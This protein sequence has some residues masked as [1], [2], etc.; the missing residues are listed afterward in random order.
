V[1]TGCTVSGA[2]GYAISCSTATLRVSTYVGGTTLA[3]A[4][5]GV[6][7]GVIGGWDCTL[8]IGATR[9][10][11]IT[12]TIPTHF[13][14]DIS[15]ALPPDVGRLTPTPAGTV[16][17]VDPITACAGVPS[18]PGTFGAPGAGSSVQALTYTVDSAAPLWMFRT[19]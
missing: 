11:T 9:C 8:S 15:P 7:T 14:N 2:A 5:G 10:A 3:T 12:G 1:F 13:I 18:G 19:P 17:N 16:L 6:T 4:G